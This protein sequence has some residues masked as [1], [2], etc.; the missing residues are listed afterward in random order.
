RKQVLD[1]Q[2][3]PLDE[4]IRQTAP[5]L[6]RMVGD[7]VTVK[8]ALR[9][10]GARVRVDLGQFEQV[11]LNLIS[12]A[13]DAING[14][15]GRITIATRRVNEQEACVEVSDNGS[16]MSRDIVEKIFEPFFTTKPRGK[17]TGLGLAS[18]RGI[19]EQQGGKIYV[20]SELGK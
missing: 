15:H 11:M 10:H 12:N 7:D 6:E 16:G 1:V 8:L 18:V 5:M 20:D 13:R 14:N 4:L 9:D 19:V 3:V 17:G 2:V